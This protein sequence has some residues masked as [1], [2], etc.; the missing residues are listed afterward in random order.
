M[1]K[2]FVSETSVMSWMSD[3]LTYRHNGLYPPHTLLSWGDRLM[4]LVSGVLSCNSRTIT[5]QNWFDSGLC[6]SWPGL[7]LCGCGLRVES[8]GQEGKRR[9]REG[10]GLE[11]L[12][13][14]REKR[15]V[16]RALCKTSNRSSLAWSVDVRVVGPMGQVASHI[17]AHMVRISPHC[18]RPSSNWQVMYRCSGRSSPPS[19][20]FF[21][22]INGRSSSVVVMVAEVIVVLGLAESHQ[23]A[24]SWHFIPRQVL[25]RCSFQERLLCFICSS[26]FSPRLRKKNQS[27]SWYCKP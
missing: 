19:L 5:S 3:H 11:R 13:R 7:R 23:E 25:P 21:S 6:L 17:A 10:G 15:V 26:F 2:E 8:K 16:F 12:W 1:K 22:F 18:L 20:L 4:R 24:Q 27:W 9:G 14:E